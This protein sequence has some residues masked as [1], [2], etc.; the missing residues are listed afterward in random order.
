M[1]NIT[2]SPVDDA[3]WASVL[4]TK[5]T[6]RSDIHLTR[7]ETRTKESNMCASLTVLNRLLGEVKAMQ[8]PSGFE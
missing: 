7:L 2:S 6:S 8:K 3:N 1:I 4:L 5:R